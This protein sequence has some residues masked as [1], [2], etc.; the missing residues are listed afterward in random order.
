MHMYLIL[1][2]LAFLM[3]NADPNPGKLDLHFED[4]NN[5][6][7]TTISCFI[8]DFANTSIRVGIFENDTALTFIVKDYSVRTLG[9]PWKLFYSVKLN[10]V[11]DKFDWNTLYSC[12]VEYDTLV[13]SSLYYKFKHLSNT[14]L[15]PRRNLSGLEY[16]NLNLDTLSPK[17]VP[18]KKIMPKYILRE[19]VIFKKI[20]GNREM[21]Y[22]K[23]TE[24]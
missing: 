9:S 7:F 20:Y 14:Y 4:F 15:D 18:P 2:C 1:T 21:V 3:A 12:G 17:Q 22:R 6:T 8:T 23:K 13:W 10:A 5:G 24:L 11:L 16:T 19:K